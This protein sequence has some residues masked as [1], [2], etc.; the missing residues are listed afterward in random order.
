MNWSGGLSPRQARPDRSET[1]TM[2]DVGTLI[3]ALAHNMC[4]ALAV[5]LEGTKP[6]G[7]SAAALR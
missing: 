7:S 6:R 3:A 2:S 5:P 1:L 4:C